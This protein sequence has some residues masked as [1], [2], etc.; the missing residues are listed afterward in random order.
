MAT[1]GA[2]Q[3]SIA[4]QAKNKRF[5]PNG[6]IDATMNYFYVSPESW[7]TRY[8]MP[9]VENGEYTILRGPSQSGKTTRVISLINTLER[10]GYLVIRYHEQRRYSYCLLIFFFFF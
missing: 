1:A 7:N 5:T 6:P 2:A 4:Q 10:E 9:K 3:Q 8:M